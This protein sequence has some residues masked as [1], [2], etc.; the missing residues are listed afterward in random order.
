MPKDIY[1]L[2]VRLDFGNN[3]E[4]GKISINKVTF[5]LDNKNFEVNSE[6][7]LSYFRPTPWINQIG[8]SS[9]SE[10]NLLVKDIDVNG[11]IVSYAPYF[12][13]TDKLQAELEVL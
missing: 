13:A 3:R 1:P 9:N 11:N 5:L 6:T 12:I 8:V 4:Q 10:Y 2:K 7:F